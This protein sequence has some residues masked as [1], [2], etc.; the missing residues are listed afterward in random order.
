MYEEQTE[1]TVSAAHKSRKHSC[2]NR[3]PSESSQPEEMPAGTRNAPKVNYKEKY[4][5]AST[6]EAVN[7]YG[8]LPAK[9]IT[10]GERRDIY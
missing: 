4:R 1:E 2:N 6:Q 3:R 5:M 9:V 7:T 10:K 8:A